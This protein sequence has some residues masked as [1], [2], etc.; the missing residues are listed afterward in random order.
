MTE[1]ELAI[2]Q[3]VIDSMYEQFVEVVKSGRPS[4][5]EEEIRRLADGRIYTAAQAKSSGLVD[6]I[7]YLEDAIDLAKK[8]AKLKNASVVRYHR[9]GGYKHNIYSKMMTSDVNVQ[10]F[11]SLDSASLLTLLSGG[12]PK[13]MYL[14]MP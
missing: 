14:W 3:G 10:S 13:F 11:P 5:S 6:E 7:G 2:F 12:T 9:A 4:L 1:E 8:K